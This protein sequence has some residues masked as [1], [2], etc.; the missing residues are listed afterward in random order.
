MRGF[1]FLIVSVALSSADC[2]PQN[3]IN[4]PLPWGGANC[5]NNLDCGSVGNGECDLTN[6]AG[7]CVCSEDRAKPDCSYVRKNPGL[8]AGL[9]IG[10]PFVGLGGIGNIIMG[11]TGPGGGQLFMTLSVYL[12]CFVVCFAQCCCGEAGSVVSYIIYI[13]LLCLFLAGFI[14]SIVDGAFILQCKF[15]DS[16][17]YAMIN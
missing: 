8:P 2:G 17:G 9:N 3:F 4:D 11:R 10:L 7:N 1:L 15:T 5:T 14:W 6:N 13:F 16:L 12:I